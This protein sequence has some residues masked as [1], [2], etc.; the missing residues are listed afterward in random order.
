MRVRRVLVAAAVLPLMAAAGEIAADRGDDAQPAPLA[1][2]FDL[3]GEILEIEGD[4]EWGAF[5]SSECST[6]HRRDGTADGIPSITGWPEESFVTVMH[7]YRKGVRDNETMR[8]IARRLSDEE[9]A[10]LAAHYAALGN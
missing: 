1:T 5:L 8:L 9:I 7:A 4:P 3:P 6:C 10:A 2:A